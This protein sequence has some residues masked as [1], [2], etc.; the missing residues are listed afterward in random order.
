VN[1]KLDVEVSSFEIQGSILCKHPGE[2]SRI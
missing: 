1:Y 2:R